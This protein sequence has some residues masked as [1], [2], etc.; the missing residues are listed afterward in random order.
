MASL[1]APKLN[2]RLPFGDRGRAERPSG[3][4]P[5]LDQAMV[6]LELVLAIFQMTHIKALPYGP[7]EGDATTSALSTT[8]LSRTRAPASAMI[9]IEKQSQSPF[10]DRTLDV[11]QE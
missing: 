10:F 7:T 4:A 9:D 2:R 11:V 8:A 5:V 6:L 1:V 3:I